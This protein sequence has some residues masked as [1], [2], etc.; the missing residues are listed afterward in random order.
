MSINNDGY[1]KYHNIKTDGFDS[2]KEKN[3]YWELTMLQRAGKISDLQRQ[4]KFELIP[5]QRINGKLVERA[6]DYI[7]DFTYL[8]AD[9]KLVVEDVKSPA[10]KTRVYLIKRKL[11]LHVHGVLVREV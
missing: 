2:I 3:R 1:T 5:A 4:V 10:T 6:C 8:D 7:A 9:G 11:M